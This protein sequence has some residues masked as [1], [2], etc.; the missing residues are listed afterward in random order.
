MSTQLTT[1]PDT[2]SQIERLLI[3]GD[4]AGLK[5]EERVSYYK[6]VCETVGLNPLTKPFEYITLNGRLTLYALKACTDQL[7]AIHNISI[8]I[9]SREVVDDCYVVT[10]RATNPSGRTDEN[11]GAV[12][13]ANLKGE[14]KCNALMKAETKAKRRVTLS[15]V[16]LGMLDETEVETIPAT[17]KSNALEL[18]TEPIEIGGEA[19]QPAV[20]RKGPPQAADNGGHAITTERVNAETERQ[21]SPAPT[22]KYITGGQA[23][24][25]HKE[26]RAAVPP[27]HSLNADDLIYKW[28]GDHGYRDNDGLPTASLIPAEGFIGIRAQ[29]IA[30]L[31]AL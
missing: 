18:T 13:I 27:K 10:A 5:A 31:K 16:G 1:R 2:G 25:F 12:A 17:R 11:I 22:V 29:A 24:N 26:C 14:A 23:R 21:P 28:L 15:I 7:R 9:M 8:T 4:L 3:S 30:W 20:E 6:M 19:I